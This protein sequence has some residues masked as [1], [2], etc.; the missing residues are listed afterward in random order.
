MALEQGASLLQLHAPSLK[1]STVVPCVLAPPS[2]THCLIL[3][4]LDK[5]AKAGALLLPVK[6]R[7]HLPPAGADSPQDR[8]LGMIQAVNTK[9]VGINAIG[10]QVLS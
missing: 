9:A 2:H 10:F 7:G 4:Y 5:D 6:G 1:P 8:A 3:A